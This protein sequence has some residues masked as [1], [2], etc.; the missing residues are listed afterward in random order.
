MLPDGSS[1]LNE[2]FPSVR[3]LDTFY[4]MRLVIVWKNGSPTKLPDLERI[5]ATGREH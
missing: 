2:K 5:S 3:L 4:P 1:R